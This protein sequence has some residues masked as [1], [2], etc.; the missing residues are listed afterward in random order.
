MAPIN[1]YTD[2]SSDDYPN[3]Y[4]YNLIIPHWTLTV[5]SRLNNFQHFLATKSS[6]FAYIFISPHLSKLLLMNVYKY[7]T[8][9]TSFLHFC[10][11]LLIKKMNG[12]FLFIY[13]LY[14][15]YSLFWVHRSINN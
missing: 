7:K 11:H 10:K 3:S 1:F 6:D 5:C 12:I 2:P 14:I 8:H 13:L 4:S 15:Y 9:K